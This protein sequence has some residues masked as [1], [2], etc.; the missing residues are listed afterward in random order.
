MGVNEWYEEGWSDEEP[1]VIPP[2]SDSEEEEEEEE[3]D[4]EA[5]TGADTSPRQLSSQTISNTWIFRLA[6][7]GLEEYASDRDEEDADDEASGTSSG[8]DDYMDARSSLSGQGDHEYKP[9]GS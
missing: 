1:L 8:S 4:D 9:R 5:D 2:I 7:L 6:S 3:D